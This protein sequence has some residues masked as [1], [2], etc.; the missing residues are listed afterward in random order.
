MNEDIGSTVAGV[1][2]KDIG[3]TVA[4]LMNKDIGSHYPF[5]CTANVFI[6]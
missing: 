6:H 1:M 4:G 2:N 3:S 5:Y